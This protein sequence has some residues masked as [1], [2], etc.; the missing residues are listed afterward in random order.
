M[1]ITENYPV[2]V[3]CWTPITNPSH[4]TFSIYN[5]TEKLGCPAGSGMFIKGGHAKCCNSCK[6]SCNKNIF[7]QENLAEF[8]R[9]F[10]IS[11]C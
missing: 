9:E 3:T 7:V 10:V 5:G 8:G 1:T 11:Q 4:I 6:K 2:A